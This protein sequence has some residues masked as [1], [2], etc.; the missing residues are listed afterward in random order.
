MLISRVYLFYV[1][2]ITLDDKLEC[3]NLKPAISQRESELM[4]GLGYKGTMGYQCDGYR[5]DCPSYMSIKEL[6]L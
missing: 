5:F 2:D 3:I 6:E 4:A 1:M